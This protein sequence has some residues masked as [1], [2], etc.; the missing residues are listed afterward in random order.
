ML[1]VRGRQRIVDSNGDP[2]N[3]AKVYFYV[4]GTTTPAV[5][6]SDSALTTPITQPVRT[7][8]AG[9]L[10][11]IYLDP[12]VTYKSVITD[13]SD[14][15]LPDGTVDPI[16]ATFDEDMIRY[17]RTAAEIA[18][19]VTPTNYYI[20]SHDICGHVL[21]SRYGTVDTTG[22]T[23]MTTLLTTAYSVAKQAKCPL[24]LPPTTTGLRFTSG[25][26][27]DGTVSVIGASRKGTTLLKDVS[28]GDFSAI[29]ITNGGRDSEFAHFSVITNGFSGGTPPVSGSGHG[30]VVGESNNMSI[31]DIDVM[32]QSGHGFHLSHTSSTGNFNEYRNIGSLY[33]GIDGVRIN[34]H[35]SSRW[36]NCNLYG[37]REY[38]WN[39]P[40]T[41]VSNSF[42]TGN[43][44][45]QANILGGAKIATQNN[46][47]QVYG[48]A[49]TGADLTLTADSYQNFIILYHADTAPTDLTDLGTRNIIIDVSSMASGGIFAETFSRPERTTNVVGLAATFSGGN[50]GA[51]ASARQ[52]GTAT[53][54]G[55]TSAGTGN[56]NG[57]TA[58]VTGGT[59]V[60]TGT[61]GVVLLQPSGGG[62]V[63]AANNT[64]TTESVGLEVQ[65]TTKAFVVSRMTAAQRDA[66]TATNGMIIY[67]TDTGVFQGRAAGAW[68]NLH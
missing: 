58:I 12:A 23:N 49:N 60:G 68:V 36:D 16:S 33:N 50:A 37:N 34:N 46:V 6:Y 10:V 45:C 19:G 1:Y 57:G 39:A 8:A 13:A 67:N 17:A 32:Y 47:L 52:G 25:L 66:M 61:I 64:P 31:H 27:W 38:G 41:G 7:N 30:I 15:A 29:T 9:F 22:S 42:H 53:L 48:E 40:T 63:V 20:P 44:T 14:V 18:A 26:T 55:G 24:R 51:G 3:N 5:V 65:S 43:V 35:S 28:G 54:Q 56:A 2:V 4:T 21:L 62:V 11:P 59:P